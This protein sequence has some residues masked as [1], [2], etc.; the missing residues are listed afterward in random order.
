M[1]I[2]KDNICTICR[3]ANKFNQL[4]IIKNKAAVLYQYFIIDQSINL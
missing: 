1:F 4:K 2:W 3:N